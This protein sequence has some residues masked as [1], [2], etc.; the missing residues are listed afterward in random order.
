MHN[1]DLFEQSQLRQQWLEASAEIR[2]ELLSG[3]SEEDALRLIA[4]RTLELTSSDAT[5][6]V[7]GPG[8]RDGPRDPRPS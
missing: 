6:I 3:A 7:L 5:V 8:P 2:N 1:A 4:Q